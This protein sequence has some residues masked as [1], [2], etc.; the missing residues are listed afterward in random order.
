MGI[1]VRRR[2]RFLAVGIVFLV[3]TAFMFMEAQSV[4]GDT[5]TGYTMKVSY[6]ISDG[7]VKDPPTITYVPFGESSPVIASI[8]NNPNN[9]SIFNN[10]KE[11]SL[12]SHSTYWFLFCY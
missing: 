3:L 1:D 5:T 10:G 7:A 4:L 12:V 2:S 8:S 9:P 11:H 6:K